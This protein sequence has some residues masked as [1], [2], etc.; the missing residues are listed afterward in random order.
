MDANPANNEGRAVFTNAGGQPLAK[1]GA[2]G[3]HGDVLLGGPN[4]AVAVWEMALT[5]M[6]R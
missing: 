4:K 3:E 2:A 5:G 6:L 1:I